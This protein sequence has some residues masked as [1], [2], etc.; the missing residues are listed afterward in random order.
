MISASVADAAA[1]GA[2]AIVEVFARSRLGSGR[3]GNNNNYRFFL[4]ARRSPPAARGS[5]ALL[6]CC[7]LPASPPPPPLPTAPPSRVLGRAPQ[8]NGRWRSQRHDAK[9]NETKRQMCSFV[10]LSFFFLSV[11]FIAIRDDDDGR[12]RLSRGLAGERDASA[13]TR[14][15]RSTRD[16][17]KT[18]RVGWLAVACNCVP[19]LGF[20]GFRGCCWANRSELELELKLGPTSTNWPSRIVSANSRTTSGQLASCLSAAHANEASDGPPKATKRRTDTCHC[21][22]ASP[23]AR[24]HV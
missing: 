5:S 12:N 14:A 19:L 8:T 1:A 23:L 21:S 4:A 7:P 9:R 2:S 16:P 10:H 3:R 15:L 24:S 17:T 22:E 13:S 6:V 18:D 20:R 11:V